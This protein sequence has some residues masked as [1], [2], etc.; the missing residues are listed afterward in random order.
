MRRAVLVSLVAACGCGAPRPPVGAPGGAGRFFVAG[1]HPYWA[2][3][4]WRSY[5]PDVLDELFFFELEVARDGSFSDAHGWPEAWRPLID[6]ALAS[7]L[8]LA[9][10][11]AMHDADAFEALF[12]DDDGVD[13]LV[14]YALDLL[15]GTPGLAGLHLDFE[16]FQP[17]EAEA[18]DGFT[19]FVGRLRDGMR[20]LD[21]ALALSVF[22]L[23]FDDA[24]V[25]DEAELARL[26]D[27]LVV[28]GYDYHS[29]D[30]PRAGPLGG[31]AGWGRL[32][33]GYVVDRIEALGVPPGKIVMAAPM[34]GYEWPVAADGAGAEARG[35]GV[36]IPYAAPDDVLPEL[37]RARVQGERHGA[38]RDRESGSL[39]YVYRDVE[40]WRQGWF[41]DPRG[42]RS[43]YDFVKRRGLGGVAIF[44]AAYADEAHWAELRRAFP[45]SRR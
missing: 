6:R 35:P 15:T 45:A 5:P 24:D 42:L 11:I 38:R 43:K 26:A 12:Q 16:V 22:T 40:G 37:P 39:Y 33:W 44:P 9:P 17:V 13:R 25:Y 8:R 18:R 41:D 31:V 32:N 29:G 3:E 10:T 34:Y 28:Q 20:A 23:A 2:G 27:Y 4:S 19:T 30:G 7:G 21:P 14:S 1:Y 36:A